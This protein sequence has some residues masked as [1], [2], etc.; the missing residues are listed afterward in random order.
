MDTT[1]AA[2]DFRGNWFLR[3]EAKPD[4]TPAEEKLIVAAMGPAPERWDGRPDVARMQETVAAEPAVLERIG[5]SLLTAVIGKRGCGPAAAFLLAHDVPL[6]IDHTAYNVLHEAAWAAAAD[7]LRAVFESGAADATGVSARPHTGWPDNLPLMY[8]AAWGGY[9]EVARLLLR[10]GA[11][12]HHELPIRG[13]GERGTTSLQE[14]LAPSHWDGTAD[15]GEGPVGELRRNARQGKLAVAQILIDDG[16]CYG[17]YAASARDDTA[18][19]RELIADDSGIVNAADPYA[20]TPLHWAA[21][22][23]STA[24]AELLIAS[25]AALDAGNR[26][27]RAPLQLA[28]EQDQAAMI[29][30]LAA[31]GADLNTQDRKGRTPLHRATYEGK[32]AAVEALLEAGADPEAR[33]RSG[34]TAFQIARKDAKRFRR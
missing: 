9:P 33:N 12:V 1:R 3:D 13:N 18:R 19:L 11:R 28:A 15:A 31:H 16:A 25:G 4:L 34:K 23:G 6:A 29:R 22:T 24:C 30:L 7:T 17:V 10:Y 21:R 5:S 14:A 32:V 2:A 8:W 27:M 20:M 26:A